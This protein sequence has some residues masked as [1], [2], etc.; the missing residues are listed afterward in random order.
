[1]NKLSI[2]QCKNYVVIMGKFFCSASQVLYSDTHVPRRKSQM[3]YALPQRYLFHTLSSEKE[4]IH[5]KLLM[6]VCLPMY[7]ESSTRSING[8]DQLRKQDTMTPNKPS[9][10]MLFL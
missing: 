7:S 8:T 9:K 3:R 10:P 1:M 5:T 2:I 6:F 4:I